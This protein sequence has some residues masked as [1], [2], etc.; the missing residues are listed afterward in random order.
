MHATENATTT[1]TTLGGLHV[2]ID[3][4]YEYI[5]WGKILDREEEKVEQI[6]QAV[7]G[8][9]KHLPW[10][11]VSIS[12]YDELGFVLERI[13]VRRGVHSSGGEVDWARIQGRT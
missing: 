2:C 12:H 10:Y 6:L 8:V 13:H 3:S 11:Q 4:S 5:F 1:R 9:K 7:G